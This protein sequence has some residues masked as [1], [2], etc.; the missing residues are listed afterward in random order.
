MSGTFALTMQSTRSD[1]VALLSTCSIHNARALAASTIVLFT[2]AL[3][4]A[5]TAMSAEETAELL[6]Y[7]PVVQGPT[8]AE[9][10]ELAA[11]LN[12]EL[13]KA[14]ARFSAATQRDLTEKHQAACDH[15]MNC[16][17]ALS[18]LAK[19][20]AGPDGPCDTAFRKADPLPAS[21]TL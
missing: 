13:A 11:G 5:F 2:T 9:V 16:Q 10:L 17:N 12:L 8:E 6:T 15:L 1:L 21:A 19:C 4:S 3:I 18:E 7:I 14:G 20:W